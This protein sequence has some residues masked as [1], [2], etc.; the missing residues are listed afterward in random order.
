MG[1]DGLDLALLLKI[2]QALPGQRTIDLQP[3]DKSGDCDEAV[4]LNILVKLL[5]GGLVEQDGVL[6]L[7]LDYNGKSC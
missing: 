7:V 3:V 2:L 4:G 6:G 1:D 5:R